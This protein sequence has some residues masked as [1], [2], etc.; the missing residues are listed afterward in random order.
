MTQAAGEV[1][2]LG[3]LRRRR[4]TLSRTLADHGKPSKRYGQD[5]EHRDR[6]LGAED[7]TGPHRWSTTAIVASMSVILLI[8]IVLNLGLFFK[9][10]AMENVAQRMYLTTKH[11][12]RERMETRLDKVSSFNQHINVDSLS[13]QSVVD[14]SYL[15]PEALKVMTW[16]FLCKTCGISQSLKLLAFLLACSISVPF[17]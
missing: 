6:S 5:P 16:F 4:R 8:L 12:L 7:T 13:G 15:N 2:K 3:G 17:Y 9:L 1:G 10:W 14:K 11:R